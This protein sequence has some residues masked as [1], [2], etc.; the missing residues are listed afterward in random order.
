MPILVSDLITRASD[1]M[2]DEALVR[3]PQD[4]RIRWINDAARAIVVRRPG[5]RAVTA[6]LTLNAGTY[7]TT[8]DGTTQVLDVVRNV[9]ANGSPGRAIR[10]AD[11]QA[12]DDDD[13]DWHTLDADITR[14][15][16]VD[17]RAPT[18]FYVY[19]PAVYGAKVDAL[20]G[21]VPPAVTDA[22]DVLDLREEFAEAIIEFMLFRC[23]T[24]DSEFANGAVAT[25]HYQAF[26]DAIGTPAAVA[27]QNSATGNSA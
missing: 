7:Q 15:Y 16:M 13:P 23:H 26:N 8:P 5:A 19:P 1:L 27:Q 24:K 21:Q 2:S 6:T 18:I 14:H 4:E 25:L 10:I 9:N 3:W 22:T 20:L 17:E 12:L 11:R